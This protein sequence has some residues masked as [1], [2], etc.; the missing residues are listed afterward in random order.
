[1][2]TAILAFFQAIPA[3]AG[4][5]NNFVSKYYDAKVQITTARIGGDVNVAKQLVTGVVAEGGVRV[6][7]LKTVSQSKFL[8]WLVAGF[9]FP[10]IAYEWKVVTWDNMVCFWIYGEYGFTPPIKG[11]VADWSGAILAGIF[12]TGSVM[13]V[14]QMYFNRR[15]RS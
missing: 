2:L 10:W 14:G 6:E 8:M 9:A 4:G 7:F 11:L 5:L 13:A 1:V 15:E 12:G 3:I